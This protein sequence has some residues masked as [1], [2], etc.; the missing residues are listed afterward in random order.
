MSR[1]ATQLRKELEQLKRAVKAAG[2][3]TVTFTMKNGSLETL[4]SAQLASDD[5]YT[6]WVYH[7]AD[8][9]IAANDGSKLHALSQAVEGTLNKPFEPWV[10]LKARIASKR[11]EGNGKDG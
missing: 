9:D 8:P 7:N 1:K 3:D 11:E 5:L 10:F 4:T 2:T 6:S